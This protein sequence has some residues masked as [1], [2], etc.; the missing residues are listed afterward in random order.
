MQQ[1]AATQRYPEP[2]SLREMRHR[3]L[4]PHDAPDVC[5]YKCALRPTAA[6]ARAPS[7]TPKQRQRDL[8]MKHDLPPTVAILAPGNM[9][10]AV[11]ARLVEK[12]A[13]VVTP[14]DGRSAASR[15][16]AADAGMAAA[17][18]AEI[19][20][21]DFVLSIVPPGEALPFAE[22]LAPALSAANGK[23]LYVD[24]NAVSPQTVVRI[25]AVVEATG[26]AFADAGIIGAPPK[27]GQKDPRFYV[28]G[29]A[30]PR[31]AALGDYGLLVKVMDGAAGEASA[32]KMCYASL[33]K[34]FTALGAASALAAERSGVAA[35]LRAE[36]SASQPQMLAFLDRNMPAMFSKAY[37]WVAE[38]EEIAAYFGADA[39]RAMLDGAARLY[40]QLAA[41]EAGARAE[42]GALEAFCA[43][44]GGKPN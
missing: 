22:R 37:R 1:V 34:G 19:A 30:A 10:A 9:G 3:F 4:D 28:S 41:D 25:A 31:V 38:M 11:G 29:A 12:G 18:D 14:L 6:G 13:R 15:A 44:G 8:D 40:E 43:R 16:R 39:E 24:C 42:I 26:C 20:Q 7:Q 2:E 32:L 23:P 5:R 35:A 27:Q 36:L 17:S 21:A 33:T